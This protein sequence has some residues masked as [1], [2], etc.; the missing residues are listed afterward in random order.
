MSLGL[1]SG[2]RGEP[3]R[4][5]RGSNRTPGQMLEDQESFLRAAA[6]VLTKGSRF[7]APCSRVTPAD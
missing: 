2:R 1:R 7:A 5:R 6:A 3:S 4:E